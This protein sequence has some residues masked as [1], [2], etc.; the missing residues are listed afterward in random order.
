MPRRLWQADH[1]TD[2]RNLMIEPGGFRILDTAWQ[3]RGA[4]HRADIERIEY[5]YTGYD[6]HWIVALPDGYTLAQH[7]RRACL[8]RSPARWPTWAKG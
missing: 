6:G 1:F 4:E 3:T 2:G 5:D 7:R 8:R